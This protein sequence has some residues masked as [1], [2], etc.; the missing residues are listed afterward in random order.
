MALI[1]VVNTDVPPGYGPSERC[2]DYG[3]SIVDA[4][5]WHSRDCRAFGRLSQVERRP[6]CSEWIDESPRSRQWHTI[7][8]RLRESAPAPSQWANIGQLKA[9]VA[10]EV[11]AH[12]SSQVTES[13][14]PA[15]KRGRKDRVVA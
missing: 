12:G 10:A 7:W 9:P 13:E 1:P 8:C 3:R 5:R 4:G 14:Q 2:L 15:P 11:V 6:V